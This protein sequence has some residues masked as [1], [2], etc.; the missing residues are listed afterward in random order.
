MIQTDCVRKFDPWRDFD[1]HL[2]TVTVVRCSSKFFLRRDDAAAISVPTLIDYNAN[3]ASR[4]R[5]SNFSVPF[6]SY[7][8][9][10][11]ED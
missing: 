5:Q 2:E 10:A 11:R 6:Y 8:I 4:L 9:G 7:Y 1:E 3:D